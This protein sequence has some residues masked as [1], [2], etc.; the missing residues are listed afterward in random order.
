MGDPAAAY[1]L[2][3]YAENGYLGEQD[4]SLALRY[5]KEG[6]DAGDEYCPVNLGRMYCLGLGT[7]I[8][9]KKGFEYYKLGYELG[10][11]LACAN[12]G[13]CYETGQGVEQ[14]MDLALRYY[15]E[16]AGQGEEHCIEALERLTDDEK[17]SF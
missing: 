14:D 2:G 10:D 4:Y 15:H 16:G 7:G 11:D 8:D 5:Y 13:Y 6:S 1:Y 17:E 12:L 9:Y 3:L